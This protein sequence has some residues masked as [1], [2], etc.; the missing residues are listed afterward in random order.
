VRIDK[1]K[2]TQ[3]LRVIFQSRDSEFPSYEIDLGRLQPTVINGKVLRSSY[4]TQI[5]HDNGRVITAFI[6]CNQK[7]DTWVESTNPFSLRLDTGRYVKTRA[8]PDVG[9]KKI[10]IKAEKQNNGKYRANL[11]KNR[12]ELFC[13]YPTNFGKNGKNLYHQYHIVSLLYLARDGDIDDATRNKMIK[14]A[15]LW[16]SYTAEREKDGDH[17]V[18]YEKILSTLN[19]HKFIVKHKSWDELLQWSKKQ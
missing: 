17:F 19:S 3:K 15:H 12:G 7:Y 16:M 5:L 18:P 11:T 2:K 10:K 8:T 13:G 1:K 14:Y 6:T 9:G 4:D